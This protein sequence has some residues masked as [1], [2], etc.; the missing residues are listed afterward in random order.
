M[1]RLALLSVILA[2]VLPGVLAAQALAAG[3]AAC[4]SVHTVAIRADGSLWA[5][6]WNTHGLLGDGTT[7]EQHSPELIEPG[8]T[9]TAVACGYNHTVAIRADGSLWAW[10]WNTY[11]QLGDGTT[12]SSTPRS[13][14]ARHELDGRRVRG[15]THRR[16]PFRWHASGPGASTT[17][18]RSATARR[19]TG[20]PRSRSRR[21]RPGR[22]SPVASS[23]P[24]PSAPTAASGPGAGTPLASS[25]MARRPTSA[26]RSRSARHDLGERRLRCRPYRRH[27]F[28]RQALGLGLQLVRPAR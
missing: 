10:G 6:G 21:G 12:T 1:K 20:T 17:T 3:G 16:H 11:G 5:W 13:R 25:A 24:S 7:T 15:R 9:W 8:T 23:T 18:A 19:P 22:P 2:T 4:G 28:R 26:R 27:P 14:S